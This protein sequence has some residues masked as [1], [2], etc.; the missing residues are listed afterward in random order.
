MDAISLAITSEIVCLN[1]AEFLDVLIDSNIF[2]L[3]D[4]EI[5]VLARDSLNFLDALFTNDLFS[6][7]VLNSV[8]FSSSN[9]ALIIPWDASFNPCILL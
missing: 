7:G 2:C 3:P 8:A 1:S 5:L 9:K 4:G 6:S